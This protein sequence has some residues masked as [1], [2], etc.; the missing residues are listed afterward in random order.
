[1]MSA[2]VYILCA[3]T[4][5]LC[6]VLLYLNFR[7]NSTRLLL[8]SAICFSCLALNNMLLFV[9]LIFTPGMDLSVVRTVPAVV[10]FAALAWGFTWDTQ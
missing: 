5:T 6:A 8:W 1:M 4:S 9:D 7:K 10:G 2:V 3:L